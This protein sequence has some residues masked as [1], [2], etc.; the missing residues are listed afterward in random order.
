MKMDAAENPLRLAL[1]GFDQRG[2]E[3]LRLAL[4]G[5]GNRHA[6]LADEDSAEAGLFNMDNVDA[7][8]LWAA[9][10]KR[11]P[12]R[13]AIVMA[14]TDPKIENAI[15]LPKP[16][17]IN[18]V[19]QAVTKI[20]D[21]APSESALTQENSS[22]GPAST[23]PGSGKTAVK[24]PPQE[25][26]EIN[27]SYFNK[28]QEFFYEP[29]EL[30]QTEIAHALDECNR[31][32]SAMRLNIM[33]EER[34]WGHITFLPSVN[35]VSTSLHEAQ[36]KRLCTTPLFL[37]DYNQRHFKE[38]E[39]MEL[40]RD[41]ADITETFDTFKLKIVLWSCM[42]RVPAGTDLSASIA[43]R[44]WPNFTRLPVIPD[45]MRITALLI[46]R[47]RPLP[48]VAKVL[49]IPLARAFN[50]YCMASTAE[51]VESFAPGT[52]EALMPQQQAPHRHRSLFGSIMKRLKGN[53]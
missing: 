39:T 24:P 3:T 51:L 23:P 27:L 47:P 48:L 16:V 14:M 42:G 2:R 52:R 1:Y 18:A 34:E 20:R 44:R 17:R 12:Q 10:Q 30:L 8:K 35:K 22:T 41:A 21:R 11:F 32:Y 38:H 4:E 5:P 19:M 6:V 25:A 28:K 29:R 53:R 49:N 37:I 33:T 9:C 50:F 46:D 40:L 15:Y 31:S 43:L 36:L 26:K 13:P 7:K 45:S